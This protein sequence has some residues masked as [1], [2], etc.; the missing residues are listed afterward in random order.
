MGTED[1]HCAKH[2]G[3]PLYSVTFLPFSV[4]RYLRPGA[5]QTWCFCCLP[6]LATALRN[7]DGWM[8]DPCFR[9]LWQPRSAAAFPVLWARSWFW[10]TAKSI[11]QSAALRQL[12]LSM[13]DLQQSVGLPKKIHYKAVYKDRQFRGLPSISQIF[14]SSE[15]EVSRSA[16]QVPAA[17]R[18]GAGRRPPVGPLATGWSTGT[19]LI[20]LCR[21]CE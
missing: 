17:D 15:P 11:L 16:P 7:S 19:P 14:S 5:N 13:W 2:C 3:L 6:L 18:S 20:G 10:G 1:L 9:Q 12:P 8:D 4:V 21:V